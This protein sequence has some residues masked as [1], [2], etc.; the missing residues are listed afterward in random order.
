MK[1][2]VVVQPNRILVQTGPVPVPGPDDVLVRV[3]AVGLC[4]S[5]VHYFA[6]KRDHESQTT[7]PFVLGHEFAGEVAGV[8]RNVSGLTIGRRVACAP[9]RPCGH[10]EWCRKGELNVCPNVRFAGSGG[11]M[12]CL[13]Q[14]YLVRPEQVHVI[15]DSLDFA[16][17]TVAE[18]LAIGLHVVDNLLRPSGEETMAVI[19]AGPIGLC[20]MFAAKRRGVGMLYAADRFPARLDAAIRLGADATCMVPQEDFVAFVRQRTSGRGVD[21][22]VEAAG[23]LETIPQAVHLAAVHGV[24]LIEGIPPGGEAAV[25]VDY[26]RRRELT[27]IF[28]RRS[29]GKTEEALE[30]LTSR[31]FDASAILTHRFALDEAQAAFECARDYRDG[32]IKPIIEP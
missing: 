16:W 13:S 24:V 23:E 6:G 19:G 22:S 32:V 31:S 3:R 14:Y 12:G 10:C 28:G 9:D 11:V 29:L 1:T 30:L 7:Y 17:A 25:D 21:L 20:V 5:D 26:A 27:L 8:G 4:G 15:P 18:P 2:A